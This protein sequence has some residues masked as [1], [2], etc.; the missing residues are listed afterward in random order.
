MI[1]ITGATGQLGRLVIEHLLKRVPKERVVAGVRSLEKG[2]ELEKLG[3]EVRRCDYKDPAS[4]S[5]ALTGMDQVLLISSNDLG[6]RAEQHQRV[7]DVA[8]QVG[9]RRLVYTSLLKADTSQM[10]LAKEHLATEQH[11]AA[12]GLS[13]AILRNGWYI[14]NY[15][16]ALAQAVQ[17]GALL[18]SAGEGK[19]APAAR[20]DFAEAAAI[21]LSHR[22][23]SQRL[24]ELAGDTAVSLAELGALMGEVAGR[25]VVYR[26]LPPKDYAEVL[27]GF[28][29][30]RPIAEMLADSDLG[31]LRGELVESS[32]TLRRLLG[33]PTTPIGS[34]FAEA[35]KALGGG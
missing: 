15:L 18:G 6:K 16:G 26:D 24:Y 5:A 33:R 4:L 23:S 9:V 27:A 14:E 25:E 11:L 32:G 31:I 17:H 20:T 29:L 22:D 10:L 19:V 13:N 1:L 7:I 12:S 8:K 21:V 34:V 3:I 35:V 30:P 2:R 28:G